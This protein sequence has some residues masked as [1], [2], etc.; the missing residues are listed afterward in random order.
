MILKRR[1]TFV[2][3]VIA[4]VILLA[5]S[6]WRGGTGALDSP[7]D[8]PTDDAPYEAKQTAKPLGVPVQIFQ[9]HKA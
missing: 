3:A 4:I 6:T 8:R 2:A 1:H 5:Q 9:R 7:Q